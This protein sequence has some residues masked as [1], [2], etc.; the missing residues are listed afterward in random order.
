MICFF[1]GFKSLYG[2]MDRDSL[3]HVADTDCLSLGDSSLLTPIDRLY[4]MQDSYFTSWGWRSNSFTLHWSL[5]SS[6]VCTVHRGGWRS[7]ITTK[8]MWVHCDIMQYIMYTSILTQLHYCL[9]CITIPLYNKGSC[10]CTI[11]SDLSHY[12]WM[13]DYEI[14]SA[15]PN[16]NSCLGVYL[17]LFSQYVCS[18]YLKN[19]QWSINDTANIHYDVWGTVR[20]KHRLIYDGDGGNYA[21]A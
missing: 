14:I 19:Q 16:V 3:C 4:S 6:F 2:D 9:L 12:V 21:E 5:V 13:L 1:S 17:Y 18:I 11:L 15:S 8:G 7:K 10:V 20:V